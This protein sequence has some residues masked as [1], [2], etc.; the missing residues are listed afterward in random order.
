MTTGNLQ[1][2]QNRSQAV[3]V[4]HALRDLCDE[5]EKSILMPEIRTIVDGISIKTIDSLV[6]ATNRLISGYLRDHGDFN[7]SIKDI[8]FN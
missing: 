7:S 2:I 8:L 3:Q 6:P 5:K 4:I 1:L